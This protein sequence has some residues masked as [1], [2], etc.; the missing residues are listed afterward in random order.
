M[1]HSFFDD[2]MRTEFQRVYALYVS[3]LNIACLFSIFIVVCFRN[4]GSQT[5]YYKNNCYGEE[6]DCSQSSD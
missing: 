6:M 3:T 4:S 5:F 1:E 2:R